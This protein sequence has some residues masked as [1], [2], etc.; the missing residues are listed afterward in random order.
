MSRLLGSSLPCTFSKQQ[1]VTTEGYHQLVFMDESGGT[2][3]TR[4]DCQSGPIHFCY[5][6]LLENPTLLDKIHR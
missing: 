3:N 5:P 1:I 4:P 2:V 6:S